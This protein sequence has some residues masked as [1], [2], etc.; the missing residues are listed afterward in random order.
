VN[1]AAR[2]WRFSDFDHASAVACLS[3]GPHQPRSSAVYS[4]AAFPR[5]RCALVKN[6]SDDPCPVAPWR[7]V[8][9]VNVLGNVVELRFLGMPDAHDLQR[10]FSTN[11]D[12]MLSRVRQSAEYRLVQDA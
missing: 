1:D 12:R 2:H 6:G 11:I 10:V 4:I 3:S 9:V 8:E 7:P 5:S